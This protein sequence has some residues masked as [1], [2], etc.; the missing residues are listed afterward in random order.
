MTIRNDESI[1]K[2][3]PS[4]D[5][6]RDKAELRKILLSTFIDED[7][8]TK[9]RYFVEKLSNG[10]RIY[11]ER[12]GRLNKGCDF[13]I[14]VEDLLLFNNNNDKYPRHQDLIDDLQIKKQ[15]LSKED[16][17]SLLKAITDIYNL[18]SFDY[19]YSNL[20]NIE[21]N[22]GWSFE[23]ILKLSRWFFIEQD[24]TYW[25][26]SGRKMLYNAILQTK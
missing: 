26:K 2:N 3:F 7:C 10:K 1:E 9:L 6:I 18:E 23:L 5:G 25:A 19:A 13:V 14:Y 22:N 16:Y 12:P 11:I 4:I 21:S 24:I 17:S 8:N 20:N 15:T